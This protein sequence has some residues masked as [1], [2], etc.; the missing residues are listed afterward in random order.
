M[1]GCEAHCG[2]SCTDS[3]PCWFG[4]GWDLV[5]DHFGAKTVIQEAM[6]ILEVFLPHIGIGIIVSVVTATIGY[7]KWLLISDLEELQR[8]GNQVTDWATKPKSHSKPRH[9]TQLRFLKLIKKYRSWVERSGSEKIQN[10]SEAVLNAAECAETLRAY[11]YFRGRWKI[12]CEL[13][14]K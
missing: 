11:G 5:L 14:R 9:E 13:R 2:L 4:L 10:S 12:Y 8:C 3:L 6:P 1:A 7:L